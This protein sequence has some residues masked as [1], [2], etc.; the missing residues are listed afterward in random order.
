MVNGSQHVE[1]FQV[2]SQ[3]KFG[4]QGAAGPSD[5]AGEYNQLIFVI[6]QVLSRVNVSALCEVIAVRSN[7]I[8]PVGF[9]D[10]QPLLNQVDGFG[11]AR[12]QGVLHNIPYMRM[13]GGVNA[14]ILDPQIGDIGVAVFADR[15]ITSVKN[16]GAQANPSSGRRFNVADGMYLGGMLNGTP[17]NF[18]QFLN[19]EIS[20]NTN[21][22]D[23]PSWA[24]MLAPFSTSN[25]PQGWLACPTAATNI[26]RTTYANLN[27]VYA[28]IG[29]PWGAGDG[30]T[31]FGMPYFAS[32]YVPVQ[33]TIATLY[34]GVVIDHTHDVLN[35]SGQT[36]DHNTY[37]TGSAQNYDIPSTRTSNTPNSPQGGSDN[38]A[39]GMGVQWCVKY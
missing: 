4:W 9:V 10:L 21:W 8:G 27:A 33:G 28:A 22:L 13:Q 35:V 36:I 5:F 37:V 15:D 31:T 23:I 3:N 6:K 34:H 11:E 2:P 12:P 38:L 30:S 32:G 26:S 29:Y 16:T 24:G 19:G 18:I 17:T 14:I 20:I 25:I 7:G 1:Y 39:A